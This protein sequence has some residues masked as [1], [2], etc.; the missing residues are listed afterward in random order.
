MAPYGLVL[1]LILLPASGC[2]PLSQFDDQ[3]RPA[4][5]ALTLTV[6]RTGD[7][8]RNEQYV[9]EPNRELRAAI[10]RDVNEQTFPDVTA[11]LTPQQMDQLWQ[12]TDA[13]LAAAPTEPSDGQ[14]YVTYTIT[15]HGQRRS[16][17]STLDSDAIDDLLNTLRKL[18]GG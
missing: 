1:L 3:T 11:I 15:A 8:A 17:R 12:Q 10:G 6:H 2:G 18:R 16:A 9:V 4:D 5:F 14:D 7:A 13:L